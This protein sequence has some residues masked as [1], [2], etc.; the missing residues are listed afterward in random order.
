MKYEIGVKSG[1][2]NIYYTGMTIHAENRDMAID[3]Y[4]T[5]SHDDV[6]R[7]LVYANEV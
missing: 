2:G 1:H 3:N 4:F 7:N 5:I 6:A